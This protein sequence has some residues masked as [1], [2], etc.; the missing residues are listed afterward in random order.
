MP[1]LA[2]EQAAVRIGREV[3]ME[4]ETV[5]FCTGISLVHSC[6]VFFEAARHSYTSSGKFIDFLSHI[7]AEAIWSLWP[8]AQ[9][10]G[11]VAT[12]K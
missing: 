5:Q 8:I 6:H 12:Q 7:I 3:E 1:L 9:E 11:M 4:R 10:T 2:A